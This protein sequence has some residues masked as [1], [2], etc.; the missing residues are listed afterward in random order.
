MKR[1]DLVCKLVSPL[2]FAGLLAQLQS[3]SYSSPSGNC[4][5]LIAIWSMISFSSELF[6]IR[7]IW[8]Q[9]PVLWQPRTLMARP[10]SGDTSLLED[11]SSRDRKRK[12]NKGI[13]RAGYI[14]TPSRQQIAGDHRR[15]DDDN[16]MG[17]GQ[18]LFPRMGPRRKRGYNAREPR[19]GWYPMSLF[20]KGIDSFQVYSHHIIFLGKQ[21]KGKTH[22]VGWKTKESSLF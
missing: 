5:L 21:R 3:F 6:L 2:V 14:T 9:S 8:F 1:I 19:E 20:W 4:S 18:A 16:D 17:E 12:Q 11:P 15:Q 22:H 7:R 13:H 10:H